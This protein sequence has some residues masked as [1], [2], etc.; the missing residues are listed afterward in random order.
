MRASTQPFR[1]YRL[2]VPSFGRTGFTRLPP[3][4]TRVFHTNQVSH[5]RPRPQ[6]NPR[7]RF[8]RG[9]WRCG[10]RRTESTSTSARLEGTNRLYRNLGDWTFA[11]ITASTGVACAGSYSTG[12]VFADIDGDGDLDLLVNSLRG[13]TRLSV[14]DG[15]GHFT[16]ATEAGLRHPH[17]STTLALADIDGDRWLDLYVATYRTN[18]I[19][20]SLRDLD[21]Q[22][23]IVDGRWVVSPPDR[24][25]PLALKN[26]G[27]SLLEVGEPDLL[28]RNRGGGRFEPLSWTDGTFLDASRHSR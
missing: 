19:K 1:A 21:V 25:I 6:P 16:E 15:Q 8:W 3:E 5:G 11:D 13:G 12:A 18:T 4:Q 9:A 28:F 7:D 10:W 27:V 22:V 26:G 2:D 14:N 23:D 17:G 24:F 20:D